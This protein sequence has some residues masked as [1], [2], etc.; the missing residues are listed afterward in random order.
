MAS[1]V[2]S[3]GNIEHEVYP[4]NHYLATTIIH[5]NHMPGNYGYCLPLQHHLATTKPTYV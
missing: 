2:K 4:S 1:I 5:S 3:V